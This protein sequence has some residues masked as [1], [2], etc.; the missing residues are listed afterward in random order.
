MLE[1]QPKNLAKTKALYDKLLQL[2][3]NAHFRS[4]TEKELLK[5]INFQHESSPMVQPKI[6]SKA[7]SDFQTQAHR[8]ELQPVQ[9][10]L[11]YKDEFLDLDIEVSWPV[12]FFNDKEHY[13]IWQ[14]GI[15]TTKDMFKLNLVNKISKAK[16]ED[17]LIQAVLLKYLYH[18][19]SEEE[20]NENLEMAVEVYR[21]L[22]KGNDSIY[23]DKYQTNI[24]FKI[25]DKYKPIRES[26][27]AFDEKF[28]VREV[29]KQSEVRRLD[30]NV[31]RHRLTNIRCQKIDIWR[32]KYE[33]LTLSK[34]YQFG[35]YEE[36]EMVVYNGYGF[37]RN[38]HFPKDQMVKYYKNDTWETIDNALQGPQAI[39]FMGVED[40]IQRVSQ[41]VLEDSHTFRTWK[42]H[43]EIIKLYK[44]LVND[45]IN[46]QFQEN[47]INEEKKLILLKSFKVVDLTEQ[48]GYG[49]R[50]NTPDYHISNVVCIDMKKCYPTSMRDQGKCGKIDEKCLTHRLVI[51]E[52]ELNFLIKN[53]TD[54]GTFAGRK[55]CPLE[56]ILTYYKALYKIE[57]IP[58]F[59]KQE[60][61]KDLELCSHYLSC[62][63]CTNLNPVS[64][65]HTFINSDNFKFLQILSLV[66]LSD[67]RDLE[68]DIWA[69]YIT[70]NGETITVQ[71]S[72]YQMELY[73]QNI[74]SEEKKTDKNIKST[75][76]LDK[77]CW[78]NKT[79]YKEIQHE[80]QKRWK[81][82]VL[83][84]NE[85]L[86]G[87]MKYGMELKYY[88]KLL[89]RYMKYGMEL[90]YHAKLFKT[91]KKQVE[92]ERC[93][94]INGMLS[95][96]EKEIVKFNIRRIKYDTIPWDIIED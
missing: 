4:A 84:D 52:G 18:N 19:Y 34:K 32:K 67:W 38:Q 58:T 65:F 2:D 66:E 12:P 29:N 87:Y 45:V 62:T 74:T 42:K 82:Q 24:V 44:Q 81:I 77:F 22:N 35:K 64:L 56:F 76:N 94:F 69:G 43:T 90:K 80:L 85:E 57:N 78:I 59:F 95:E 6:D 15:Q 33:F 9:K 21:V 96:L 1:N 37:P 88:A 72:D 53:Y 23:G 16:N 49:G 79:W 68:Y 46:W 17:E 47:I 92:I 25:I 10:L 36:I 71:S 60:N 31:S 27:K 3:P 93:M 41:F 70:E 26:K 91:A 40:E 51:Y 13:A 30:S 75:Q 73:C 86:Q 61:A 63:I 39:W 54:T 11:N 8:E 48:H 55:K 28:L 89:Q 50:W 14:N 20:I 5:K 7:G 83:K